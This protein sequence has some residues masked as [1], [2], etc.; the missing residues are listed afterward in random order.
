[1]TTKAE[2]KIETRTAITQMKTDYVAA[3]WKVVS[4]EAGAIAVSKPAQYV[5]S[6]TDKDNLPQRPPRTLVNFLLGR[7]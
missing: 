1:M 5:G 7:A 2:N 6:V 3:G 4:E